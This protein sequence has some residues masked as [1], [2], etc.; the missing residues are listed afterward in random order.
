L[1]LVLSRRVGQSII[2]NGNVRITI[3]AVRSSSNV[4]VSIEAPSTVPIV[5]SE[6]IERKAE[7]SFQQ[8]RLMAYGH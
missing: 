7:E 6:L 1:A 8:G 3:E 5:R 4:S 2:I